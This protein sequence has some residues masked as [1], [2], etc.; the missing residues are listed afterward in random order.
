AKDNLNINVDSSDPSTISVENI[1]INHGSQSVPVFARVGTVVNPVT[2]NIVTG[3]PKTLTAT[4][5][6]AT[7]TSIALT[8]DPLIGKIL[9]NTVFPLSFYETNSD[10]LSSFDSD[11]NLKVGPADSLQT[12]PVLVTKGSGVKVVN[13]T[14]LQNGV[15]SFYVTGSTY[16]QSFTM[17]GLSSAQKSIMMDFS[18]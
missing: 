10:V 16:S 14:I 9:T 11:L 12:E 17:E 4:P 2:L 5:S 15:Q 7:T 13:A 3:K 18:D 6:L 1:Q 8:A